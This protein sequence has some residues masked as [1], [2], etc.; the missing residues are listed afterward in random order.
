MF[1]IPKNLLSVTTEGFCIILKMLYLLFHI[2]VDDDRIDAVSR[3]KSMTLT[4][5]NCDRF[6]IG[7]FDQAFA[8]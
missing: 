6:S 3:N 1:I 5:H 4:I 2:L 7:I 8:N